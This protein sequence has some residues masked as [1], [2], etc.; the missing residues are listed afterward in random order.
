MPHTVIITEKRSQAEAIGTALNFRPGRA[1]I[2]GDITGNSAVIL[3]AAGH[4]FTLAA[5]DEVRAELKDWHS[6]DCLLPIPDRIPKRLIK[7]TGGRGPDAGAYFKRISAAL[8][9]AS[10]AILATDAD[11]EGEAIGWSI[12]D[13]ARFQ[14]TVRRAWLAGGLDPASIQKA[15]ANLKAPDETKGWCRASEARAASDWAYQLL[16]RAHTHQG[17]LGAYGAHLGQGKGR[18]SVVSVGRVQTP[19]LALIHR[20]E[21]QIRNFK[22]VTHTTLTAKLDDGIQAP[23]AP[24]ALADATLPRGVA[25]ANPDKP[26]KG[27]HIVN[28]GIA[29]AFRAATLDPPKMT[30]AE[31]EEK[32]VRKNPPPLLN[33]TDAQAAL[34]KARK[35]SAALAQAVFEDLYEQG[36]LSYP[37]TKH[38]Q[39]PSALWA[40]EERTAMLSAAAGIQ[41]FK[42]LA[43][44]AL[45]IH[46]GVH[47]RYRPFTPA[48]VKDKP[49][50]HYA[51]VPTGKPVTD[52]VLAAL[53]PAKK[54][55]AGKLAA[56][57][58][59]AAAYRLAAERILL[60]A[61][62]PAQVQETRYVLEGNGPD[63]LERP[64]GRW[65]ATCRDV[66]DA[67]WMRHRPDAVQGPPAP[68]WRKGQPI[69]VKDVALAEAKTRPP[70]RYTEPAFL[71]AMESVG[72]EVAD[73]RLRKALARAD[74]IGT[75]ATRQSVLD[76]LKARGFIALRKSAL[77]LL[78]AGEALIDMLP[79]AARSPELTALWEVRLEAICE[80]RN[81]RDAVERRDAFVT[82]QRDA[83]TKLIAAVIDDARANGR[84]VRTDAPSE[85]LLAFARQTAQALGDTLTEAQLASAQALRAYLD[86][87]ESSM[88]VDDVLR[89]R[90]EWLSRL[91]ET[92]PDAQALE[93][94]K[95]A[96]DWIKSAEGRMKGIKP[97]K[98]QLERAQRIAA[99]TKRKVPKTAQ[100]S[101][102][103][104]LA[105]TRKY[106]K[107]AGDAANAPSEGAL[108]F[109]RRIAEASGTSIPDSALASGREL[110][111]WID[112]NKEKA[113]L[114]GGSPS[115]KMLAF[116]Q[117][118]AEDLG[119]E[120]P[121][122][123]G[124]DLQAC[125]QWIDGNKP[126]WE[127]QG[128][129]GPRKPSEKQLAF[130][131]RIAVE[132]G[133][134]LTEEAQA[135]A[136]ACSAFIDQ[137]MKRRSG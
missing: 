101:M 126:K 96:M 124:S 113:D 72:K 94:R 130:A 2:E 37:R 98:A 47:P 50:E 68:D 5:P 6:L 22:S 40:D 93:S 95:S 20:R 12:L 71:K 13:A 18:A 48:C 16:T 38:N 91:S 66:L 64:K 58:D 90:M 74:G 8:K 123:A 97:T 19:A 137:H 110:A 75:P 89:R 117:R 1:G 79:Q 46:E 125:R 32:T 23:Y 24:D 61:L 73:E 83:V 14:G 78:D 105:W 129:G 15:F 65:A 30:V 9:G 76:T 67:G 82:A 111:Q 115:E 114:G 51:I 77:H 60:N 59:M 21:L 69:G 122:A 86:E 119:V 107:D 57:A 53:K 35:I 128:G 62:P 88:P 109:A 33:L 27:I 116:A 43:E 104:C 112:A 80:T 39:I 102:H 52:A 34:A 36:Y 7:R 44:E 17:R 132:N 87:R 45:A 131:H 29:A 135:S 81:D 120:L 3:P 92:E 41:G 4:L 28:K 84:M 70:S 103:A 55:S 118:I 63:P 99:A 121:K 85:K 11:R 100:A 26:D 49:M 31:V 54:D 127:K 133:I 42:S 56:P 106:Q 10:A 25:L 134:E 136:K 108:N